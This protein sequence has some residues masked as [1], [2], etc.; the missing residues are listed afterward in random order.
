MVDGLRRG[1]DATRRL[2]A[3][4][5]RAERATRALEQ[6]LQRRPTTRELADRL[7]M[8]VGA[9]HLVLAKAASLQTVKY[10]NANELEVLESR[11]AHV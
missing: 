11:S 4:I 7:A 2:R 1:D 6:E 9:L 3:D 5:R 10:A 8:S